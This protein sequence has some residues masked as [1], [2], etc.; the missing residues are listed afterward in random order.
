MG[1]IGNNWN[2]F[3]YSFLPFP[4]VLLSR[5]RLLEAEAK[6]RQRPE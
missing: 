3:T 2:F 1:T 6:E 4:S 5:C